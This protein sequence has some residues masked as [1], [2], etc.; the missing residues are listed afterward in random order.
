MGARPCAWMRRRFRWMNSLMLPFWLPIEH[1]QVNYEIKCKSMHDCPFWP[2]SFNHNV[3]HVTTFHILI[4]NFPM[5]VKLVELVMVYVVSNVENEKCFFTLAFM[6][7]KFCNT[8]IAHLPII[9]H[10]C[11]QW[12]YIIQIFLTRSALNHGKLFDT[13]IV[14]RC[15]HANRNQ[16]QP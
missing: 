11:A 6:K 14:I 4:C 1:V 10:M 3:A 2:K 9:I 8:L 16:N 5:H 13:I 7:F 15:N 12:Y